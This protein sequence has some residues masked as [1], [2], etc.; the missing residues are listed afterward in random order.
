MVESWLKL[1]EAAVQ[2]I[3]ACPKN[4]DVWL[5]A[6]RLQTQE[7]ARAVLA[8]GVQALPTSVKLWMQV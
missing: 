4:E 5:E 3:E 1:S 8:R 2:G 6:A 7:N